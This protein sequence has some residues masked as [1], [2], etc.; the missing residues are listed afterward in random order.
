MSYDT[1]LIALMCD[2]KVFTRFSPHI[3]E[4]AVSKEVWTLLKAIKEY[5]RTYPTKDMF[6][7]EDMKMYFFMLHS[8]TKADSFV[9]YTKMFDSIEDEIKTPITSDVLDEVL[10]HFVKLDYATQAFNKMHTLL[11]KGSGTLDELETIVQDYRTEVGRSISKKDLFVSTTLSKVAEKSAAPGYSWRLQ[12]LNVSLGPLR[13]GNFVI[14]AARPET[15]KTTKLAEEVTH[16]VSQIPDKRPIIWVNNE[17]P[18]D[19]VMHRIIQSYFGI[20]N[21]TLI[22]N[23]SLY[24]KKYQDEVGDQ[25]LVIDD[26]ADLNHVD[27][28]TALFADMNPAIIVFD[29]LDKVK[30]FFKSEREDIRIGHLYEWARRMAKKYG[31]VIAASQVDGSGEGQEWIYM[32]QLRGSKTDKVGEADAIIT[33]GKSNNSAKE[34]NRYIHVPKNKLF[35]GK[36]SKEEFRHGYFEVLIDPSIARYKGVM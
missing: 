8:K 35:G 2:K 27:K 19:T 25:I 1:K 9:L 17:E 31:P 33:I 21:G 30:G 26:E 20:D 32:N 24:S 13:H 16:M 34:Y 29:Q 5:Y 15:G 18:S 14:I 23:L 22:G 4:Y 11:T 7:W 12:E 3:K 28:L 36:D 6:T 10:E